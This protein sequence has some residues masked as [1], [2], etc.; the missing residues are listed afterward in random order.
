MRILAAALALAVLGA[1]PAHAQRDPNLAHPTQIVTVQR[2]GYT[3]AGLVTHLEGP[4]AFKHGIALFPG[5]PGIFK[6]R[7]EGGR[8]V[9][10]LRGNFLMRSRRHW[11][12]G[13]TLVVAV[14]APSDHWSSFYQHFRETHHGFIGV[15]RETV[16]AMRVW[17]KGG[18]AP[19][20]VTK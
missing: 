8:A 15:E 11:L 19:A 18:A 14:D 4:Q 16:L 20:E 9:F 1:L 17:A 13:E 6:L 7:E 12:D 10:E 5:H 2:D 3:I